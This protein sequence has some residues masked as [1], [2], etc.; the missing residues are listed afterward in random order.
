MASLAEVVLKIV[1]DHLGTPSVALSLGDHI[2]ED[3]GADSL[4]RL[5]LVM[6]VEELLRMK[7]QQRDVARIARIG[8]IVELL[9]NRLPADLDVDF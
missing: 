6:T 8:D 7:I 2:Q 3:L 4:D 9:Q 5:E 1:G